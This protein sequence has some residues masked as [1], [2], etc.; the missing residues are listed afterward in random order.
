MR[1]ARRPATGFRA[2]RPYPRRHPAL[3]Q[4]PIKTPYPQQNTPPTP[5]PQNPLPLRGRVRV[6]VRASHPRSTII[7]PTT[8]RAPIPPL[9]PQPHQPVSHL[10]PN[11]QRHH[12]RPSGIRRLY[13]LRA[14]RF[15]LASG[16]KRMPS[17]TSQAQRPAPGFRAIRPHRPRHPPIPQQHPNNPSK[18]PTRNKTPPLPQSPK[19]PSPLG[20]G[21]GWG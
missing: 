18:S 13:R 1:Q 5:I 14:E 12:P 3:P 20:G 15:H 8:P 6:G 2:V 19:I 10:R 7:K 17:P 16:G 4:Q 21:L 9:P 11:R